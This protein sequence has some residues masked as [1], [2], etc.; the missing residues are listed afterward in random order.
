MTLTNGSNA[1]ATTQV[2]QANHDGMLMATFHE[3]L[4]TLAAV[5]MPTLSGNCIVV[6]CRPPVVR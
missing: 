1:W 4:L 5:T 2:D 6:N 3:L